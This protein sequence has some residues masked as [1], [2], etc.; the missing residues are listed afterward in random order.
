MASNETQSHH[1]GPTGLKY[2]MVF[3]FVT[4]VPHLPATIL[5][6]RNDYLVFAAC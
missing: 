1:R 2:F 5:V 6:A 4:Y 3:P